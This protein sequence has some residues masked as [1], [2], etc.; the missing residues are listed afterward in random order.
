MNVNDMFPSRYLKADDLRGQEVAVVIGRCQ[1]EDIGQGAQQ[2]HE[3]VLYFHGKK[4]GLVLNQVNGRTIAGQHGVDSEDWIG[5]QI[6]LFP[7]QTPF[8][9]KQVPCIRVKIVQGGTQ[10]A[11]A[12]PEAPVQAPSVGAEFQD[13]V[14]ESVP[15]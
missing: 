14:D 13:G 12:A 10:P 2:G 1:E 15:F 11:A 7:T 6:V 8:Q 9:G 3:H 5:K 4:K